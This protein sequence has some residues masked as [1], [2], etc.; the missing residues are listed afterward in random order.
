MIFCIFLHVV[1]EGALQSRH[2]TLDDILNLTTIQV[3]TLNKSRHLTLHHILNL[4]KIQVCTL[5]ID[6]LPRVH[7]VLSVFVYLIR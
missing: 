5:G 4:T 6:V 3:C 1:I 7:Y 2:L